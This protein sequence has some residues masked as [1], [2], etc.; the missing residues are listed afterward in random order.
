MAVRIG[1]NGFGRIGRCVLRAWRNDSERNNYEFVVVNDLTDTPTLSHLLKYD[2]VHGRY[3][4]DVHADGTYIVADGQRMLV[5]TEK[6]FA[7]MG[8]D[9]A[10][11]ELREKSKTL[12]V[13]LAFDDTAEIGG[14]IDEA[15]A[16]KR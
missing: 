11:R 1:I 7:R 15:L 9:P 13:A 8:G 10:L 3:P 12:P 6:D 16:R 2:S 4:G 14:F 5:T